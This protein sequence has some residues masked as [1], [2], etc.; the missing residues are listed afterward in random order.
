[1]NQQN[2]NE[3]RRDETEA[4]RA[5]KTPASLRVKTALSAGKYL[6]GVAQ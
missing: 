6:G 2:E 1:M 4:E 3:P 5:A